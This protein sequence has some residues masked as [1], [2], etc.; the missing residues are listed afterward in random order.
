[1]AR[2]FKIKV[3]GLNVSVYVSTYDQFRQRSPRLLF[4]GDLKTFWHSCWEKHYFPGSPAV[5]AKPC[6]KTDSNALLVNFD[7]ELSF[8]SVLLYKREGYNYRYKNLCVHFEV[9]SVLTK[10][11]IFTLSV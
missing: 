7:Q 4:D 10:I 8:Q 5:K 6:S 1:M 3:S 9:N 2:E 11:M